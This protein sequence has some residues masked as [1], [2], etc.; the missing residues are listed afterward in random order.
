MSDT[1]IMK[2]AVRLDEIDQYI[3]DGSFIDNFNA[4]LLESDKSD[5]YIEAFLS[6]KKPVKKIEVNEDDLINA[7][8]IAYNKANIIMALEE[9]KQELGL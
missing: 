5:Q 1:I 4:D 3:K 9:F 2:C 6:F 7:F 8:N